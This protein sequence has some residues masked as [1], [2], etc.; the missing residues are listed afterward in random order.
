MEIFTEEEFNVANDFELLEFECD[1]CKTIGTRTKKQFRNSRSKKRNKHYCCKK[2]QISAMMNTRGIEPAIELECLNCLSHFTR[3]KSKLP[4][5]K[6]CFCSRE[7]SVEY[8]SIPNKTCSYCSIQFFSK[9]TSAKF[10]SRKCQADARYDKNVS[11]WKSGKKNGWTGKTVSIR[12]FVRK[13]LLDKFDNKCCKCGWCEIH[14]IT[15]KSP[16]EV[17]HINGDATDCREENLEI[18]CPNC[19]SLTFNFRALNKNGMRIRK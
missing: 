7:C 18:L 9:H 11:E 15:Q 19:H 14:P 1:C 6:K 4:S 8:N 16:L 2:C 3:C 5:N 13:Y 12:E 17:N 10:C